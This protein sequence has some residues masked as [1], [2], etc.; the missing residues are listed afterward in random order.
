G[1]LCLLDP[2]PEDVDGPVELVI[3]ERGTAVAHAVVVVDRAATLRQVGDRRALHDISAVEQDHGAAEA[4][5]LMREVARENGST[6]QWCAVD[7]RR[8]LRLQPTVEVVRREYA[9]PLARLPGPFRTIG[10]LL[11]ARG[12]GRLLRHKAPARHEE[13]GGA[14]DA[15]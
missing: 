14:D 4:V 13:I 2:L 9:Q 6:A 8:M 7:P 5:P 15:A 11:P 12:S 1:E 3:A 10:R